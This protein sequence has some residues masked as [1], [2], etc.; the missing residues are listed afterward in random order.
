M[1]ANA[2]VAGAGCVGLGDV[3]A[4]V[5]ERIARRLGHEAAGPVVDL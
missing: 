5:E 4:G 3:E 1:T 2:E